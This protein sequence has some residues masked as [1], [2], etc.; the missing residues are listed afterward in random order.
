MPWFKRRRAIE[1]ALPMVGGTF[2]YEGT[3]FFVAEMQWRQGDG[4]TI[5]LRSVA[6]EHYRVTVQDTTELEG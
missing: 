4:L 1:T 5:T 2:T 6:P 3:T